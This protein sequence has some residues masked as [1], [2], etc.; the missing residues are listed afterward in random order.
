MRCDV[1]G[2]LYITRYDKGTVA[3]VS[4]EGKLVREVKLTGRKP[5]NIAFGGPDGRTCYVTVADSRNI[6]VFRVKHPGR[7]W[8]LL[9]KRRL[10]SNLR[11]N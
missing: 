6:E 10:K 9:Q 5:S 7:A 2:N 8:A 1:K 3:I 11:K 4:A